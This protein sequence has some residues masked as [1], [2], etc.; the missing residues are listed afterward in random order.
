KG[1]NQLEEVE[2]IFQHDDFHAGNIIMKDGK[3]VGVIDF[4]RMD[5]G[6]YVQDFVKMGWFSRS[7]NKSF[8]VGQLKGYFTDGIPEEFWNRYSLYMA[9]SIIS[10]IAWHKKFFPHLMNEIIPI[11]HMVLDDHENFNFLKPNWFV[12]EG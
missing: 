2:S 10:T 12:K 8:A 7:V 4:N 5:W 6:D 3:Y 11:I 1:F 9:V